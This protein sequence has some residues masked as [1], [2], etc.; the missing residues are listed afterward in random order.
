VPTCTLNTTPVDISPGDSA[1]LSWSSDLLS[2]YLTPQGSAIAPNGSQE[3]APNQ[4][5][6]YTL[7]DHAGAYSSF[8]YW[9]YTILGLVTPAPYCTATLNVS[10][11]AAAPTCLLSA[12]PPE[13]VSGASS[14]LYYS[15][16][17]NPSSSNIQNV[18]PAPADA[19]VSYSVSPKST[20]TYKL[21][22]AGQGGSNVCDTTLTVDPAPVGPYV[23]LQVSPTRV[24]RGGTLIMAWNALNV[25]DC[26]VQDDQGNVVG[27][28]LSSPIPAPTFVINQPTTYTLECVTLDGRTFSKSASVR[29]SPTYQEY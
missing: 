5:T 15:I 6:T 23:S 24:V 7:Y 10:S 28:G 1:T 11:S 3:V 14:T 25:S 18:G 27:R 21:S 20:T 16:T 2:P 19:P 29:F 17:G 9:L 13:I 4:T 12:F 26:L 22:V 8:R